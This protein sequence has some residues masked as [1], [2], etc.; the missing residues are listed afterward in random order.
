MPRKHKPGEF[1]AYESLS[2]LVCVLLLLSLACF[3]TSEA[4]DIQKP[5]NERASMALLAYIF[6]T[7]AASVFIFL[8]RSD[9]ASPKMPAWQLALVAFLPYSAFAALLGITPHLSFPMLA[10]G[11][12][13]TIIG[14]VSATVYRRGKAAWTVWLFAAVWPTLTY[15]IGLRAWASLL[16]LMSFWLPLLLLTYLLAWL[17]PML[18]PA[19]STFIFREQMAPQTRAGKWL[20]AVSF[21][22]LP[23]AGSMG[24]ITGIYLPRY[25]FRGEAM[26]TLA[27]LSTIVGLALAQTFSHQ[28]WQKARTRG[29]G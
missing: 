22:V 21:A 9:L 4:L 14:V 6:L 27:L 7:G 3:L 25:G 13:I 23:T 12:F 18:H 5:P 10:F 19:L 26:A 16:P 24:A 8:S 1:T 11:L 20:L 17:L 28:L 15:A 2:F 29:R